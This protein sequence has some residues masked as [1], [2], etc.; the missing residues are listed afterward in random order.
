LL[1]EGGYASVE[2]LAGAEAIT[3]SYL[4]RVMRLA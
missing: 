2:K 3:P 4:S 1:L